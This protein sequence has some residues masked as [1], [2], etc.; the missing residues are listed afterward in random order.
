MAIPERFLEEVNARTDIVD[1]ISSYV[2]LQKKGSRYWGCC[3]FHSEKTPSFC[4]TPEKELYYCF[5][6]HKGGNAIS[7]I[8]EQ[9]SVGFV[10]AVTILAQRAGLQM[11]EN[12]E[13]TGEQK[14]RERLYDLNKEAARFFHSKLNAPEGEAGRQ[15]LAQRRLSRKTITNFGLGYAPKKWDGL[16][17]AMLEKGYSKRDLLD[18]GLVVSNDKG[19]IYD[20]F[21]GRVMFP[22]IDLRGNVIGFGGRVLNDSKPKYLN[23]PDTIIYN[24]SRNLFALNLAKK[25]KAGKIILTEGYMDT[26]SLHQG[27]FDYAVAS[28][29]TSLTEDHARLLAKYAKEVILSYDGDSAGIAAAQRAIGVLGKTGIAVKVLRVKGAKDPDEFIQK[30]GSPAFQKLLDES[31]NQVEYRL[32]QAKQKYDLT[33]DESRIA[34]LQEAADIISRLSSP[35]EREVYAGRVAKDL[36][37]DRGTMISE[38]ERQRKRSR[39]RE[40]RQEERRAMMP[41]VNQQ[42]EERKFRYDNVRSAKAE[43]GVIRLLLMDGAL[44]SDVQ[45]LSPEAFSSPLL[46]KIYSILLERWKAGRETSFSVMSAAL[47]PDELSHLTRI[48]HQPESHATSRKALADYIKTIQDEHAKGQGD[49]DDALLALARR[50]NTEEQP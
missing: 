41:T 43:E 4:V 20:R 12:G 11:P 31:D 44:F 50:K 26:I 39:Y 36:K 21:R 47:E 9:E 29:G 1:L 27:G 23:S 25:S 24:K 15:Y 2:P 5:G 8:M 46:S 45:Q 18:A 30:Y 49:E 3:P 19:N 33:A 40:R 22:I 13:N 32:A 10:D 42:P 7:F 16:I 38:V 14:K 37:V 34:Y 6:C 35:V 28:L 48:L 17:R